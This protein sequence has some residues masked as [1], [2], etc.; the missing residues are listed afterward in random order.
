MKYSNV[1]SFMS[2]IAKCLCKLFGIH[3]NNIVLNKWV[4]VL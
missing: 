3:L 4:I 2:K 1:V